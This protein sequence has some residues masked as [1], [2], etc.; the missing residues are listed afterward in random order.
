MKKFISVLLSAILIV[1]TLSLCASAVSINDDIEDLQAQFIY[2]KGPET[3]G[4]AIDYRYY[5]PVSENDDTKYP[6]VIWLH[7][8]GDGASD[9]KQIEKSNISYWASEEY[10]SRF[11]GAGG[12]FIL[13]ARS[14]E[15]KMIFWDDSMIFPLRAAIDDFIAENRD[16]IDISKIYIGGYSMGGKM[17]LKMAVAY[18]EMFAA[19]FP[20]C[21]AWTPSAEQTSLIADIPVWLTSGKGD[22]LVNYSNSVTPTWNNIISTSSVAADC[23][24]S[25]LSTV[26]Y[27][28]G[29]KTESAHFAWFA[30]NNDMF[31]AENGDY[32]DMSTVNGIGGSVT[33]TYPDG[34]ISW[35]SQFSSDFD[36]TA[37]TDS[38]NITVTENTGNLF[39]VDTIVDFINMIG[40]IV[41]RI[42]DTVAKLFR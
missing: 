25:T 11:A 1:S 35:L 27:A 8:M 22:P 17:T 32:P 9:G 39:S 33:L 29:S 24:F 42:L 15:E 37:A 40:R 26:R 5:S 10:Q 6:L 14:P 16:N 20:I 12:M 34:M 28:D 23:R 30:V 18:P 31:S 36:G 13:A 41:K 38:G 7:G 3:N 2:G 19:A 4:Y 21:P